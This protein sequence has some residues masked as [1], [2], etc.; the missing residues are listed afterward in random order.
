MMTTL[1]AKQ[2]ILLVAATVAAVAWLVHRRRRKKTKAQPRVVVIFSGKR[3]CGKDYCS[4]LLMTLFPGVAEIGRLSGPLKRAYAEEHGL[5]YDR[6]LSADDYK[7]KYRADMI[8]WGERR[9][10][11]DPGYFGSLV[12]AQTRAPILIISDA[13]RAT[14]VDFFRAKKTAPILVRVN[15]SNETRAARG[16][17]FQR[18][19]DDAESE[20]GLDDFD[21]WHFTIDNEPHTPDATRETL[22]RIAR[23]AMDTLRQATP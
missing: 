2:S 15:A 20:C 16:W 11:E 17:T 18:G 3:K 5:D 10:N 6:L 22:G 19:V 1:A 12:L 9:R 21:G 23:L 4:D 14:D 7:E 8:A 13:R